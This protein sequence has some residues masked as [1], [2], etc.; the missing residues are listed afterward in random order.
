[1][2]DRHQQKPGSPAPHLQDFRVARSRGRFYEG[3]SFR[4]LRAAAKCKVNTWRHSLPA[5]RIT[6][7]G[8]PGTDRTREVISVTACG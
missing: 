7:C 5:D 1:M 6:S 8:P 4:K 2:R 3:S